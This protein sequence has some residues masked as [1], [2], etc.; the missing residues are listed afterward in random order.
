MTNFEDFDT[1]IAKRIIDKALSNGGNFADIFVE[2]SIKNSIHWSKNRAD[3]V[4]FSRQAGVGVRVIDKGCTG[5]SF[6]DGFSEKAVLIAA[7][8]ASFIA[9]TKSEKNIKTEF[10]N[11][12]QYAP[13]LMRAKPIE[14]ISFD[15]KI[16]IIR[17]GEEGAYRAGGEI[18]I[19]N[20][21]YKDWIR[22]IKIFNS[23]GT[24][25]EE[26][27]NLLEYYI[28][29]IAKKN[30]TRFEVYRTIAGDYGFEIFDNNKAYEI[31]F[32]A[33][34]KAIE[35]LD[36]RE[37]PA[38]AMPVVM[39]NGRNRNGVLIHEAIGHALESDFIERKT[40]V[41]TDLLGKEVAS[42]K[43]TVIDDATLNNQSGSYTFD[44]EG[45]LGQRKELIKDGILKS[46]LSDIKG[47]DKLGFERSGNGRRENFRYPP[48]PR[49][50]CTFIDNGNDD[51]ESVIHEIN[52]GIYITALGGGSGDL[53]GAGFV[54]NVAEGYM[55][56]KGK[57]T[58]PIK[59]ASLTG[60]GLDVLKNIYAVSDDLALEGA[61]R[62]GKYQWVP[63]STG[64]PSLAIRKMIVG[65]S[66]L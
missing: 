17:A 11:G 2:D 35:F 59:G 63:V 15:K 61:G 14:S 37:A 16:D 50:S 5:Y 32:E 53:N 55:I 42:K 8:K 4:I 47:A 27:Q 39:D 40:S 19:V 64:Q 13:A 34:E 30:D 57:V 51:I 46:Y 43:V 58:Y 21:V 62:C 7:E 44:D 29:P 23:Y 45:I 18:N 33:G 6:S 66:E 28:I 1:S 9:K 54:F 26:N 56:E 22:K 12:I 25:I 20:V 49:M 41:Y 24:W 60:T 52:K 10:N 38:G 31:G 48:L 36:A 65:G 3:D